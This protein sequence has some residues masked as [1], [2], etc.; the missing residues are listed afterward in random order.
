MNF[1]VIFLAASALGYAA[2]FFY[3]LLS[4]LDK[5]ETGHI[6]AAQMLRLAFIFG[7][8]YFVWEAIRFRAFVP[9]QSHDQALAFFGWSL[10]FVY[11]V[12]L[13]KVRSGSFGLVLNPIVMSL[14]AFAFLARVFCPDLVV[15][16]RPELR[17]SFFTAHILSAF[18]AYAFFG[19]SFVASILYLI[20]HH[21]L[22]S[23]HAGRFYHKLPSLEDLERLIYQPLCW[24]A[25][26]LTGAL[27]IGFL[28]AKRVFGSYWSGDPK[29]IVTA[30]IAASYFLLIYFYR[31]RSLSAKRMAI[32]SSFIFI[33][34]VLSFIGMRFIHASHNYLQ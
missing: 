6:V 3:H 12:P 25:P 20:Q 21:E 16:V 17:H 23:K 13:M 15:S 32:L 34:V 8:L 14:T 9:V 24:G 28:W 31:Q 1:A 2:A 27:G 30:L 4:F 22:K 10:A 5:K 11:L 7:T 26:L 33:V 29:T 18:F 19:I